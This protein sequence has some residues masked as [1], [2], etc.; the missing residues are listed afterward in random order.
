MVYT[1]SNTVM[2]GIH[3]YF[4]SQLQRS[5]CGW[6]CSKFTTTHISNAS[7]DCFLSITQAF[8]T[9][10]LPAF[11]KSASRTLDPEDPSEC[12]PL[13]RRG[14]LVLTLRSHSHLPASRALGVELVGP[15]LDGSRDRLQRHALGG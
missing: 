9:F 13:H 11:S 6:I 5:V 1:I 12:R 7:H 15:P 4:F 10:Y 8:S 14:S 3:F 2:S